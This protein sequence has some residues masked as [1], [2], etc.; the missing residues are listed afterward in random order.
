MAQRVVKEVARR[1]GIVAGSITLRRH[2]GFDVAWYSVLHGGAELTKAHAVKHYL[3][4]GRK[5]GRSPHPLFDPA[6]FVAHGGPHR[7]L[8][9]SFAGYVRYADRRLLPTHPLFD[10]TGYLAKAPE[11]ARYPGGPIEHYLRFG[12]P[13]LRGRLV[14]HARAWALRWH[15]ARA[16]RLTS[17]MD[18][19]GADRFVAS[20]A[21]VVP[22]A[23]DAEVTATVII[24]LWNRAAQIGDAIDS[25]R[26][27]TLQDWELLVVDDGS[28]DDVEAVEQ[29]YASDHRIRFLRRPHLGVSAA[30]N[31]GLA[32]ARGRYLAWLDSDD[33]WTPEHLRVIIAFMEREGH[34]AAYDILELRRPDSA[35][36]FRCLDGGREYLVNGNHIGQTVLVHERSLVDEIGGYDEALP[37]TVDYDFILRMSAVTTFGFAPFVGCIVNHDPGDT[38]RITRSRPA[39]WIDVVLGRNTLD[40]EAAVAGSD[41][42]TLLLVATGDSEQVVAAVDRLLAT[43]AGTAGVQILLVDNGLGLK[44]S[45]VLASLAWRYPSVHVVPTPS[46]RGFAL[47]VNGGVVATETSRVVLVDPRV[48]PEGGWLSPLLAALDEAGVVGAQPAGVDPSAGPGAVDAMTWGICAF[49]RAD[50]VA[51]RGLDPLMRP[52]LAMVDLSRRLAAD[53]GAFRSVEASV[54]GV[55]VGGLEPPPSRHLEV[56]DATADELGRA[57]FAA[58]WGEASVPS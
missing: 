46:D 13:E 40:W 23:G 14:E 52:E 8:L 3:R 22:T 29:K 35:P 53:R 12:D 6:Y 31:A 26:A 51:V 44:D 55:P 45:Q 32:E 38:S 30:R 50:L 21:G 1:I 49:R 43:T 4:S 57:L 20:F 58:R 15:Y 27:Q 34:R 18:Q 24:P 28:T 2:V 5:A 37:R 36:G 10:V 54:V 16:R 7:I 33:T 42:V 47:A 17:G 25:V 41:G 11:A 9:E 56:D 48:R 19:A 39:A